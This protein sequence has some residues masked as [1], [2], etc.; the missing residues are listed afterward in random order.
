MSETLDRDELIAVLNRLGSE[1][2]E[3]ALEAARQIHARVTA[4]GV[5]WDE[6]LVSED[7]AAAEPYEDEED[8]EPAEDHDDEPDAPKTSAEKEKKNREALAMIDELLA[9]S[10]TS[11]DFKAELE[12]YKVDIAEDE[13]TAADHRYIRAVHKRLVKKR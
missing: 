11:A 10:E 3:E 12:D 13:F 7:D 8:S 9:R 1:Q 5:T 2:D 4:A 6:L